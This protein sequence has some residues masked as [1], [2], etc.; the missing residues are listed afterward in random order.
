[1]LSVVGCREQPREI[2][3]SGPT[4]G[5]VYNIRVADPPAS[6]TEHDVREAV[7]AVL[8][9]ID[10][11]MSTYRAD[12]EVSRFNAT[13]STD[14]ISVSADLATVVATAQ[15]VSEASGGALDI[16]V[17]PLVNLWG[18][19]PEGEPPVLP[20]AAALDAARARTGYRLLEVRREPASLRKLQ[21]MLQLDLNAVAPGFAVDQLAARFES[22]SMRNFM[23]DIG[24]EVLARGRNV[25]GDSWHI[26]VE[27][28]VDEQPSEPFVILRLPGLSVTTSGE[29]R[30]YYQR[31]GKRYS[32]TIDPRTARPV[33]HSLAAVVLIGSSSLEVD[34][35]ATA[36][37]VLGEVEGLQLAERRGMAAMFMS[38]VDGKL[39]TG[40]TK[41]FAPYVITAP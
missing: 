30:H 33:E 29:Y 6:L 14:W 25:Q 20:D 31:D 17:A 24:G 36:L 12:S 41:T 9:A 28:P 15:Q 37:N 23:I 22:L 5:T 13:Q 3:L 10:V 19:G 18:F 32:H 1:M 4:M 26:A 7:D 2:V 27:K 38:L 35:W 39:S 34:A 8:A 16:T 11:S 40:Q 21:P